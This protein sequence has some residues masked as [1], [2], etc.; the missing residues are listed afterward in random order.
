MP[1][2]T[3]RP[4]RPLATL[5]VAWLVLA[6]VAITLVGA[7]GTARAADPT[8]APTRPTRPVATLAPLPTP[9]PAPGGP[10]KLGTNVT[11]HGRGWGH[12][13]GLSQ[14]GARG[15]ALAGH[16]AAA[17]LAHYY[18]GT[19]FGTTPLDTPIRVRVLKAYRASSAPLE[20]RTLGGAWTIDGIEG[21]FP[22]GARAFVTPTTSAGTTTWKV[23]VLSSTGG[24]LREVATTGFRMRPAAAATLLQV[25][26]R[27]SSYDQ[28]RGVLRVR[29]DTTAPTLNV[30]NE[31]PLETY[32]RG[33]VPAEMPSSWPA[34]ALEA[35]TVAARSYAARRLR[36]GESW[37]D[38]S[39]DTSSQVYLGKEGEK[40]P[41][42]AVILATAGVVLRSGSSIANTLF[43]S[44]GGGAT[45]HNE[46]VFVSSTGAKVAGPV[47]YLRGRPDRAP[48]GTPYDASSPYETWATRT[49][50]R[51]QLSS[52]FAK[53]TRTNVGTLTALD[54]RDRGV[55]GRLISVKLIG[56]LGTKTV[57]GDVFR[58]VFNANRPSGD[59]S[60]RSS[61]VD[62]KPVP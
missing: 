7:P 47:A 3:Q 44:T 43:H 56:S 26:S 14:Y 33:V 61:L 28:Y 25:W 53:D 31:L 15:R 58:S 24:V 23:K 32:L 20:L 48:D 8:P 29:L 4:A 12:G 22:A 51:T 6:L 46:N 38:V 2:T 57:S 59:P 60:M 54:L 35:Q 11:F 30:I 17:I 49:Y 36:P 37:Y 40:A 42:D 34:E 41:T 19:T 55:S 1:T 62:T 52:W 39:D 27:P 16:T 5:T 50:T 45:E 13:V 9:T 10:T 21:V 18:Q